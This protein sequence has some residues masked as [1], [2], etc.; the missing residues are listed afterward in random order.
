MTKS[1]LDDFIVNTLGQSVDGPA[2][3][4]VYLAAMF[5]VALAL[6]TFGALFAGWVSWF[7]RRGGAGIQSRI[8]PNRVGPAG[9]A[10]FI[11]DALKL[12]LKEDLVPADSDHRLFRMAPY[13]VMAG[14]VMTFVV[15]PFGYQLSAT[16]MNVGLFYVVSITA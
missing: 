13:F 2:A 7:E 11:A 9:L 6:T 4:G 8:G 5:A 15:L 3:Y 12:I 14:F 10:Q 1:A 16:S